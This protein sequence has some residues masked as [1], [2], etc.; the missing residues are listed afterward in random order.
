MGL[1]LAQARVDIIGIFVGLRIF[2]FQPINLL[3]QGFARGLEDPS[4]ATTVRVSDGKR[5]L[6]D[7]P[8]AETKEVLTGFFLFECASL[9]EAIDWA[10]QLPTSRYGSVE[11]R[12]VRGI[13]T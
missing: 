7:G 2:R 12:P 13:E 8:F 1:D 3:A 4:A 6:T 5:V 9:D 10:A 11:V